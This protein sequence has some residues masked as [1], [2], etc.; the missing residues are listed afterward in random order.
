[1]EGTLSWKTKKSTPLCNC[2]LIGK[3]INLKLILRVILIVSV[4][5]YD[6]KIFCP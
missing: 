3:S 6:I 2:E 4:I 1:M 5:F